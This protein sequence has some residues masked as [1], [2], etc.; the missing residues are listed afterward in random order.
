MKIILASTSVNRKELFERLGVRFEMVEPDFEE[1]LNQKISNREN[2]QNFALGKAL[3]VYQKLESHATEDFCVLGF[4][5]MV[6]F[7]KEVI[8]KPK[9]KADAFRMIQ[10]FVGKSQKIVSGIACV[11]RWKGKYFEKAETESTKIWFKKDTSNCQIRDYLAFDDWQGK[12]GS[13][14][15]LGTGTFLLERIEGDFQNIIGV[16]VIRMGN[17]IREITGKSPLKVFEKN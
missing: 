14:S 3:S 17:M 11:G 4:D 15:I 8:G 16:P 12:C 13:Y 1:V 5:S 7:E 2:I 6:E 9:S 10:R